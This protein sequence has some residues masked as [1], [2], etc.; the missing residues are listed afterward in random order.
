MTTDWLRWLD[1]LPELWGL[2]GG[3]ASTILKQIEAKNLPKIDRVDT[4]KFDYKAQYFWNAILGLVLTHLYVKSG[5][6]LNPLTAFIT[7]GA[8][9]ILVKQLLASA[10]PQH[11]PGTK[12]VPKDAQKSKGKK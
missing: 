9:P 6:P 2:V 7:G 5:S 11:L 3:L 12:D 10:V 1:N 8:A 4:T